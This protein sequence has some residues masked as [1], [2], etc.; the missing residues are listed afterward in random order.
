M[1]AVTISSNNTVYQA[2][3]QSLFCTVTFSN[4]LPPDGIAVQLEWDFQGAVV[5]NDTRV[6]ISNPYITLDPNSTLT[7]S[8]LTFFPI[9]TTDSGTYTCTVSVILVGSPANV[10]SPPNQ[11]GSINVYVT[12]MF[13]FSKLIFHYV[14]LFAC[15]SCS[16]TLFKFSNHTFVQNKRLWYVSRIFSLQVKGCLWKF[17]LTIW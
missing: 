16:Q 13:K 1:V 3:Q 15:W 8:T 14:E 6:T 7:S 2:T 9:N 5:E 17:C 12:G 10:V 4:V 11:Q